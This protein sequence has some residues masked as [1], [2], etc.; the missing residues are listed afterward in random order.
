MNPLLYE[1]TTCKQCRK[2]CAR[3]KNYQY[4]RTQLFCDWICYKKWMQLNP[5]LGENNPEWQGDKASYVSK[6]NWVYRHFGKADRCER[7]ECKKISNTFDWAN[8]SGKYKRERSDWVR[9][10][11]SCHGIVD[12]WH[13]KRKRDNNGACFI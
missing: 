12:Q 4:N 11:R 7:I 3:Y 1:K 13:L 2:V 10:C 9:L 8:I 5:L 6:H